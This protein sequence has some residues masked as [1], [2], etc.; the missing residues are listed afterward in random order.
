MDRPPDYPP[1]PKRIPFLGS[2]LVM[3]GRINE[4][5]LGNRNTGFPVRMA[6]YFLFTLCKEA[7]RCYTATVLLSQSVGV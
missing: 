3:A 4:G 1:S 7:G 2:S 5:G 6:F